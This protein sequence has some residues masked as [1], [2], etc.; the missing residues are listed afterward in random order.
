[1]LWYC[2]MRKLL[3]TGF[4]FALELRINAKKL[5]FQ[6]STLLFM[7]F[8]FF[9]FPWIHLNLFY[10]LHLGEALSQ[11]NGKIATVVISWKLTH[12]FCRSNSLLNC[13]LSGDLFV[14]MTN[15][16]YLLTISIRNHEK[17]GGEF[18]I[19]RSAKDRYS[20]RLSNFL[21]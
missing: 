13:A 12:C 10:K 19:N 14:W 21:D 3:T 8:F 6:D 1:M 5:L 9:Q 16:Y 7:A 17:R 11:H 20:D 4:R 15:I 2:F 18:F